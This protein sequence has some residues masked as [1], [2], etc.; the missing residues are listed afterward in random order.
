M[1]CWMMFCP[2]VGMV[3]GA[4]APVKSELFLVVVAIPQPVKTHVHGFGTF[5]LHLF[6]EDAF[7]R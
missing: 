3:C 5:W 4:W 1:H 2:V 7:G 6:V